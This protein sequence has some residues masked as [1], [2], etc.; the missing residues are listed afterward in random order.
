LLKIIWNIPPWANLLVNNSYDIMRY[1][2]ISLSSSPTYEY[3][4]LHQ[5]S[6][7]TLSFIQCLSNRLAWQYRMYYLGGS[8]LL[9]RKIV[10]YFA[11]VSLLM[12]LLPV[13]AVSAASDN[14]GQAVVTSVLEESDPSVTFT[15]W[16]YPDAD[17][18]Y[19]GGGAKFTKDYNSAVSFSFTGNGFRYKG[20][21]TQGNDKLYIYVDGQLYDEVKP[22]S[23][24]VSHKQVLYETTNLAFGTHQVEIRLR[25]KNENGNSNPG[26]GWGGF[27]LP[28]EWMNNP[29]VQDMVYGNLNLQWNNSEWLQEN[30]RLQKELEK[31]IEKLPQL[32]QSLARFKDLFLNLFST[33]VDSIEILAAAPAAPS[34][35]QVT[36]S[37]DTVTLQWSAVQNALGYNVYRSSSSNGSPQLIGGPITEGTTFVDSIAGLPRNNDVKLYYSISAIGAASYESPKSAAGVITLPK[38]DNIPVPTGL[39]VTVNQHVANLKWNSV[40]GVQGYNIYRAPAGS[41]TYEKLNSSAVGQSSYADASLAQNAFPQDT[42][43]S[44][45]V[46]AIRGGKESARSASVTA[47]FPKKTVVIKPAT[48]SKPDASYG[49]DVVTVEWSAVPN[50]QGYKVYRSTKSNGAADFVGGPVL[51]GTT[52]IDPLEGVARNKDIKLYYTITALGSDGYETAKSKEDSVTAPKYNVPAPTGLTSSVSGH[53][54][55]LRWDTVPGASDYKVYRAPVG[56]PLYQQIATVKKNSYE[57][58]SLSQQQFPADTAYNYAV[59]AVRGGKDSGKSTPA[60]AVFPKNTVD[61]PSVPTGLVA[62]VLENQVVEVV[63]NAA[64]NAASYKVYRSLNNSDY[65]LVAENLTSASYTDSSYV[66]QTIVSNVEISYKVSAMATNGAETGLSAAATVVIAK[67]IELLELTSFCSPNPQ[68]VQKWK[69]TNTNSF[70]I[71]FKVV[72]EGSEQQA[73][74]TVDANSEYYLDTTSVSG[75]NK[76]NIFV[77]GIEHDSAIS[78]G[79]ACVVEAPTNLQAEVVGHSV[80][81]TWSIVEGAVGYK[82]YR[83]ISGEAEVLLNDQS[84]IETGHYEDLLRLSDI[85]TTYVISYS[86]SAIN[87]DGIE[88]S[89]STSIEVEVQPAHQAEPFYDD[90]R[91]MLE[92]P[93][94]ETVTSGINTAN[95]WFD[96]APEGV[97]KEVSLVS[98]PA[99]SGDRAQ[100]ISG[101]GLM[102]GTPI[103]LFQDLQ[104]DGGMSYALYGKLY[105]ENLQ[106]AVA[107]LYV[108]FYNADRVAIGSGLVETANTAKEY[109]VLRTRGFAPPDAISARVFVVLRGTGENGSGTFYVD[110][111][112][113]SNNDFL[114]NSDFEAG[115]LYGLGDGWT[116][117]A[118]DGVNK[119]LEVIEAPVSSG[120]R[121]QKME[122]NGL[123]EGASLMIFQDIAVEENKRFEVGGYFNVLSLNK[124]KVQLYVDFYNSEGTLIGLKVNERDVTS[125]GFEYL[126]IQ[127]IIP[128]G[129]RSARVYAILRGTGANGA[130]SIIVDSFDLKYSEGIMNPDFELQSANGNLADYWKDWAPDGVNKDVQIVHDPVY[131]GKNAKK[132]SATSLSAGTPVMVYQDI[133]VDGGKPYALTGKLKVESIDQAVA[134]LYIEFYDKSWKNVGT[135]LAERSEKTQGYFTLK[136]IGVIPIDATSARVYT[137]LRGTGH[138]GSGVLYVDDIHFKYNDQLVNADF[139]EVSLDGLANG[140]SVSSSEGISKSLQIVQSPG[141][142]GYSQ[143]ISAEG[144]FEGASLLVYQDIGVQDNKRFVAGGNFLVESINGALIQ[145]YIDFYNASDELV[146]LKV[147]EINSTTNGFERL[148]IQ[149]VVP[150]NAVRARLYAVIRGEDT[151]GSASVYIDSFNWEYIS[152]LRNSDFEYSSGDNMADQWHVWAPDGVTFDV[153]VVEAP[154]ASREKALKVS[155]LVASSPILVYQDVQVV[156]GKSYNL[157]GKFN[158]E[159]LNQAVV[160]LYIELF[161]EKGQRISSGYAEQ[162]TAVSEYN[163]L[164]HRGF[165]P[166]NA[167]SARI[168]A[169]LRGLGPEGSGTFYVD[170]IKFKQ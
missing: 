153:H 97:T 159:N 137:I 135:G 48:P 8:G 134:Q 6:F 141:L 21:K 56:N 33:N 144:L 146:G 58:A 89:R 142:D 12:Q 73:E 43:F 102:T 132:I 3:S 163:L 133:Q 117:Y 71:T 40:S 166:E 27:Q 7:P 164:M 18:I 19:S 129:A 100:R 94:F 82:V 109:T 91:N 151:N 161:D 165:T 169:I 30:E 152:G 168:Y 2:A 85:F 79:E 9:M 130:G 116:G 65:S 95:N 140:W 136:K 24:N 64:P 93:S 41:T 120:E 86:I 101:T 22:N 99:A 156:G 70:A 14:N 57:D 150:I 110:D 106:R 122:A 25:K 61:L 54:A 63:W 76:V 20:S 34:A 92:N 154:V 13:Y 160:Q 55:S 125:E 4:P 115:S 36:F 145:L 87:G 75:I 68:L 49:D 52:F 131:S 1:I 147:A 59:S 17:T 10:A 107:Q 121:A 126:G 81:L 42:S 143:K 72:V 84:L 31:F 167:K 51:N 28:S 157:S 83:S 111:I 16:W 38:M 114:S 158:V 138:N 60:T 32:R 104:I 62:S 53:I 123:Y 45:V 74:Y 124:A 23:W 162:S 149:D 46:T 5:K 11:I 112:N 78:N 66:G 128:I 26:N 15:G 148:E 39:T 35:P 29:A 47:V 98:A 67:N 155:G 118:S 119:K 69:V 139:E 88:S 113:L 44:Y 50:A 105:V 90:E 108:E 37:G 127:D 103:L 77:N 170:D 80:A 96:W